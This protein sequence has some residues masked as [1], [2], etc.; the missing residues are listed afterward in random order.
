MTRK[1]RHSGINMSRRSEQ[2]EYNSFFTRI[3][4]WIG[5][6][7]ISYSQRVLTKG[8]T[9]NKAMFLLKVYKHITIVGSELKWKWQFVQCRCLQTAQTL[10]RLYNER[11]TNAFVRCLHHCPI[12]K[13][14]IEHKLDTFYT[15]LFHRSKPQSYSYLMYLCDVFWTLG[16]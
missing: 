13:Q 7:D 1:G 15:I 5:A 6:V 14:E 2:I 8:I 3:H 4:S 16:C 11:H 9:Q 12:L 10:H